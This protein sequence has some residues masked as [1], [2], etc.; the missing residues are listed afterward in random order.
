MAAFVEDA[1]EQ[2]GIIGATVAT[3]LSWQAMFTL[4]QM[5]AIVGIA[6]GI[7]DIVSGLGQWIWDA[8][9]GVISGGVGALSGFG[10]WLLDTVLNALGPLGDDLRGI[11]EW[12]WNLLTGALGVLSDVGTWLWD[13]LTGILSTAW[14][15]IS[16]LGTWIWNGITGIFSSAWASLAN[17]GTNIYN[18]IWNA[19]KGIGTEVYNAF[20]NVIATMLNAVAEIELPFI[21][22]PF[23]GLI[24]TIP[25]LASGGIVT[26]PTLALIGEKG[27]EKVTPL[28][29]GSFG[30]GGITINVNA[31]I[32]G[33]QDLEMTF[34]SLMAS[35][36]MGYASYR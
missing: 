21:G 33:V 35:E 18:G 23:K 4:A 27:P 11:G 12:V 10:G 3:W 8:V 25:M 9:S 26:S 24:G 7:W 5:D 28:S 19:I 15:F 30:D 13:G 6:K 14:N 31:P 20:H 17:L 2:F 22:K 29:G 1:D 32:Y 16:G 36:Q 34:R